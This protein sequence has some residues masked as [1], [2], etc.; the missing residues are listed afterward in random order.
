M[1]SIERMIIR[2]VDLNYHIGDFLKKF[3]FLSIMF[4]DD[5]FYL[6]KVLVDKFIYLFFE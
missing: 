4:S 3:S 5:K 6:F 2:S 1:D